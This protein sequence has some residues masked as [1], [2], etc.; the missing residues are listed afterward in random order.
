VGFLDN[1]EQEE[2]SVALFA[3]QLQSLVVSAAH[4]LT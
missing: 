1:L 2:Q 3:V 4:L